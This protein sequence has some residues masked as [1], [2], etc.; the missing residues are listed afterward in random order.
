MARYSTLSP[1]RAHCKVEPIGCTNRQE[2]QGHVEQS[3]IFPAIS[4]LDDKAELSDDYLITDAKL[5]AA[6]CVLISNSFPRVVIFRFSS[7]LCAN[8]FFAGAICT[9]KI[10]ASCLRPVTVSFKF[11]A[12][13]GVSV[14]ATKVNDRSV[15]LVPID[16]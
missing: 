9:T 16:P 3:G 8:T 13:L 4:E 6:N 7:A 15:L 11:F 10:A 5:A 2:I 1:V 12:A 14:R